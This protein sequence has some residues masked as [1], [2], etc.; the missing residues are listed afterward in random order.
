MQCLIEA[1]VVDASYTS[2]TLRDDLDN[3]FENASYDPMSAEAQT[4]FS[5]AGY[6]ISVGEE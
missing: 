5:N 3:A 1:G 2:Q 4:C 6:T